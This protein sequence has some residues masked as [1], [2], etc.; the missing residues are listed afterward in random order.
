LRDAGLLLIRGK[1]MKIDGKVISKGVPVKAMTCGTPEEPVK[2][3][4]DIKS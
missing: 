4:K 1:T 3:A 2:P